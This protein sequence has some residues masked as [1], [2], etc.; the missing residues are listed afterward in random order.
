MNTSSLAG[1]NIL[2]VEDNAI[3]QMLVRHSLSKSGATIDIANNGNYALTFIE[4]N[5]YDI[6]LMDLFMPELDGYQTT[7][8][9]RK[10]LHLNIPIVAMTAL[11]IRGEAEKCI[12]LGMN[13][14]VSKPF[15]SESLYKELVRVLD[16]SS[17]EISNTKSQPINTDVVIDLAFLQE[18]AAGEEAYTKATI[19]LFKENMPTT[20]NN[21]QKAIEQQ[22]WESTARW[23]HYCKSTLSVIKIKEM[24]TLSVALENLAKAEQNIEQAHHI[25]NQL[26]NLFKKVELL[27]N[28]D[29]TET[30]KVHQVA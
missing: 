4:S 30:T 8:I 17:T 25:A 24:Y 18:L 23:A 6:I 20:L 9:I 15:T 1:K 2:V 10:E 14:Y 29:T 16:I 26:V 21:L 7:Q 3:N 12:G 27:L 28:K 22:N 11:A 19:E 13:G 5:T